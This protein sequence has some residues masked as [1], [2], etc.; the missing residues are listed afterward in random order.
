MH[1]PGPEFALKTVSRAKITM[2]TALRFQ[3][4]QIGGKLP[5]FTE[6]RRITPAKP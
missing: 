2:T 5:V 6:F 4:G 1:G 3:P